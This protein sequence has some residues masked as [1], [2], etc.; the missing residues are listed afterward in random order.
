MGSL[1]APMPPD[2]EN[3]C[4]PIDRQFGVHQKALKG[5]V[6]RTISRPSCTAGNEFIIRL[7]VFQNV[8]LE[9]GAFKSVFADSRSSW[10]SDLKL[11]SK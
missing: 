1:G 9:C 2:L 3:L 8:D 7:S 6:Y 11:A 4:L 10:S 5:I